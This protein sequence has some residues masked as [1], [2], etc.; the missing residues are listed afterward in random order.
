MS[1]GS[2]AVGGAVAVADAVG[3]TE[4]NTEVGLGV[5]VPLETAPVHVVPFRLKVAGTGLDPFQAPL[6]PKLALPP[7]GIDPLYDM[8]VAV[9]FAPD[10]V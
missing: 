6:N 7:A 10:C 9:T 2:F 1:H 4:V 8:F 3:D 5:G